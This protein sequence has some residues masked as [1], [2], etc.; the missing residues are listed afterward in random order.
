MIEVLKT[1]IIEQLKDCCDP[2]LLDLVYKL[3]IAES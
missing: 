1:K 2:D 3:L